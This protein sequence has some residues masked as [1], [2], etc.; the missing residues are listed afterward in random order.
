MRGILKSYLTDTKRIMAG[1]IAAFLFYIAIAFV[2]SSHLLAVFILLIA[3]IL[4]TLG[5][6]SRLNRF[7]RVMPIRARVVVLAQYLHQVVVF[8]IGVVLCIGYILIVANK[9]VVVINFALMCLGVWVGFF[10]VMA[11]CSYS[12]ISKNRFVSN[13]VAWLCLLLPFLQLYLVFGFDTINTII[14]DRASGVPITDSHMFTDTGSW[15]IYLAISLVLYVGSY[16][17]VV[18]HYKKADCQPPPVTWM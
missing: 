18:E 9:D 4:P 1:R 15:V 5:M 7:L 2:Q 6:D 13:V 3:A 17:L 12:S 11:L 16:F 8:V 10:A 14:H